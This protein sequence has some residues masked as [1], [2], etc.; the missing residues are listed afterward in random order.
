M[1]NNRTV[2]TKIL[3]ACCVIEYDH[4]FVPALVE[5]IREWDRLN[6]GQL[7]FF[8]VWRR[9]LHLAQNQCV[10]EAERLECSHVLFVEDDTTAIPKGAIDRLLEY[11]K[12]VVG[13]YAYSR[14]FPHYPMIYEKPD[15]KTAGWSG[16]APPAVNHIEPD[17]GLK[18]VDL[19]PFQ[20]TMVKMEVFR[21]IEKP[22][23]FYNPSRG[24]TD[25]WF[26]DQC[27]NKGIELWCDT[28]L[29]VQ[30]AGIDGK[31]AGFMTWKETMSD[32]VQGNWKTGSSFPSL[33]IIG[34]EI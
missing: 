7:I 27:A 34:V 18:K 9:L 33:K 6:K 16:N 3:V 17:Q 31:T 14:H 20:F 15:G 21:T 19:V 10:E 23:F 2:A 30:H 4:Q 8:P 22:W 12:E 5:A 25:G 26:V 29:I 13:A 28:D 1:V 32:Q 11:D 24:G